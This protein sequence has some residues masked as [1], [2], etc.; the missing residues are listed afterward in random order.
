MYNDGNETFQKVCARYAFFFRFFSGFR[1]RYGCTD[2]T[3]SVPTQYDDFAWK[4]DD[5]MENARRN[6]RTQVRQRYASGWVKRPY[7]KKKKK[8]MLNNLVF[9][10]LF[11]G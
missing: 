7:S 2:L 11:I 6:R 8:Q 9:K 5:L 3:S 10:N 4:T 1:R